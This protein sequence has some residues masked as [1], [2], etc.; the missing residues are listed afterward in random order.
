MSYDLHHALL[1]KDH[2]EVYRLLY[3]LGESPTEIY[4]FKYPIQIASKLG[5]V[6]SLRYLLRKGAGKTA[7]IASG[8]GTPSFT[9]TA[10]YL[11]FFYGGAE[12]MSLLLEYGVLPTQSIH[13]SYEAKGDVFENRFHLISDASAK[14]IN[15]EKSIGYIREMIKFPDAGIKSDMLK[16]LSR[17]LDV[18]ERVQL[19]WS[20]GNHRAYVQQVPS[21]IR[22]DYLIKKI[23]QNDQVSVIQLMYMGVSPDQKGT[24]G[25]TPSEHVNTISMSKILVDHGADPETFPSNL[26]DDSNDNLIPPSPPPAKRRQGDKSKMLNAKKETLRAD[27]NEYMLTTVNEYQLKILETLVKT[28]IDAIDNLEKVFSLRHIFKNVQKVSDHRS[29]ERLV[30]DIERMF[31]G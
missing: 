13:N 23:Q 18:D 8:F 22:V 24:D 9:P 25:T 1:E 28:H 31:H 4:D 19:L 7:N 26:R 2:Q 27:V 15:R 12:T 3:H 16:V 20:S 11:A 10:M 30:Q 29:A 17:V 21:K 6:M 5:D 14:K